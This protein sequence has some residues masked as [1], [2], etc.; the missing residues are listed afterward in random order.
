MEF[1]RPWFLILLPLAALP[2]VWRRRSAVRFS[3][4]LV[5]PA[6][7]LSRMLELT[8]RSLGV[9]VIGAIVVSLSGPRTS[10][11]AVLRWVRGARLIFV[12]DQ[13]ASMFSPWSGAPDEGLRKIAVAREAIGEFV[14]RRGTDQVAL[15]GFGKSSIL[16]SPPTFDHRRFLRTVGL[17]NTDLGDTLIDIALLRAL[18][19]LDSS[20]AESG[21]QAVILLSDG[22]GRVRLPEEIGSRFRDA[23]I[24]LYWLVI[25]GGE[26]E[27]ERMERLMEMAGPRART[28]AVGRI[29]QLPQALEAVGRLEERV[30]RVEQHL[31]GR[32]WTPVSRAIALGALLALG[33]FVLG[34]RA[35]GF[36]GGER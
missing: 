9:L 16:Y 29:N 35:V 28:F 12:L 34:D 13:S 1:A 11:R 20:G 17:L 14:N 18:E 10:E 7:P 2:L 32:T 5:L 21:G 3:S 24:P 30:I 25:E 8:E 27:D 31:E 36:G 4:F 6:D 22:A 15:I 19:L 33:V 26:R 23:E